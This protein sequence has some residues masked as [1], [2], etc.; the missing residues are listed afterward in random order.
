[1]SDIALLWNA[2][3]FSAD[4]AIDAGAL[5][6][7]DGLRTAI[8]ISLFTDARALP[9]DDV[10]QAGSDPRGWWGDSFAARPDDAIGSRLWLLDR[11]KITSRTIERAR[12]YVREALAWL[13]RDGV[14]SAIDVQVEAQASDRLAIGVVLNRPTGPARQRF[15][16]VWEASTNAV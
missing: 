1:M 9:D 11:E 12:D 15:D 8:L 16:Y 7:D 5:V 14:A 4:I 2:D 3:S 6:T 10:P 13:I